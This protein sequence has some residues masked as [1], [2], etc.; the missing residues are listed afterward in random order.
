VNAS[1]SEAVETWLSSFVRAD[2]PRGE[3]ARTAAASLFSALGEPQ[4][5]VRAVHV[6]GTAGK[7]TAARLVADTLRRSGDTVGLHLSPHVH[8]IRERFTVADDLPG[9]AAVA[10]AAAEVR[11][12]TEHLDQRPTFFAVTAAMAYVLARRAETDWLVVEAGIGGRVDATN[13]FNRD[14]VVTVVTAIGLDHCDVLGDT[15]EAIAA[16]KMAVVTGRCVAVLGPQPSDAVVAVARTCAAA[17]GVRLVEVAPEHDW[18]R[19]AEATATA[20]VAELVPDAP[21]VRFVEQP[22]RFEHH[23]EGSTSW[24]F[25]GAH[26][27]MKLRAL[28]SSLADKP[29]PRVGVVA[30]GAA[31]ALDECATAIAPALDRVVAVTF[32]GGSGPQGHEAETVAAAFERVGVP[33]WPAPNPASAAAAAKALDPVTVVVTGSF[34]HLTAMRDALQGR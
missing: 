25:D 16:E 9:W 27:P 2:A 5:R 26:N 13:T 17:A 29:R 23:G 10:E 18:R 28:A 30:I 33:A 19:D 22:G 11:I 21:A 14:D 4:D 34:L 8:D 31:K 1:E 32:G 6:V 20:V 12:A 15:V 24:I 3:V 7:G